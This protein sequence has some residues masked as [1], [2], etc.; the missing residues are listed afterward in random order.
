MTSIPTTTATEFSVLTLIFSL[1]KVCRVKSLFPQTINGKQVTAIGNSAFSV[2][3]DKIVL[4]EGL[5]DIYQKAFY[6]CRATEINIPSAVRYIGSAAF[7]KCYFLTGIT[8]PEGVDIIRDNTF[9]EC[10]YIESITLPSTLVYI[11]NYAFSQCQTLTSL[12]V[13]RDCEV[14]STAFNYSNIEVEYK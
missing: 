14:E 11:G 4:P 13:P 12:T 2:D 3:T 8:I 7:Q 5:I 9:R 6:Q 10:T 1:I